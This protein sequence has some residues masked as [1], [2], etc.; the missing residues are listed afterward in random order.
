[1][2]RLAW[3]VGLLVCG[4]S[5]AASAFAAEDS[6]QTPKSRS[7]NY[8][9]LVWVAPSASNATEVDLHM[10]PNPPEHG[11][12][13]PPPVINI[14]QDGS[15]S[16]TSSLGKS[17]TRYRTQSAS[18]VRLAGL[19]AAASPPPQAPKWVCISGDRHAHYGSFLAVLRQLRGHGYEKIC[20]IGREAS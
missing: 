19:V 9:L 17:W 12:I 1:M 13:W 5:L 14:H 8:R 18:L 11:P 15:L 2:G 6:G 7:A 4:L 16:F 20:L 3:H 10:P